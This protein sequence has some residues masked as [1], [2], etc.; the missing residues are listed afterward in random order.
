MRLGGE[1]HNGT[2]LV[3]GEDFVEKGTVADIASHKDVAGSSHEWSEILW[4]AGVS[5]LV[6][7]D[8]GCGLHIDPVENEV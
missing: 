1:I 2:R 8:D 6:K 5:E 3:L 4:V 7:I